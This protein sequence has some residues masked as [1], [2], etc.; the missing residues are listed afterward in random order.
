MTFWALLFSLFFSQNLVLSGYLGFSGLSRV[1]GSSFSKL[2]LSS[3]VITIFLVVYSLLSFLLSLV[4]AFFS[5]G[6]LHFFLLIS[7]GFGLA[8]LSSAFSRFSWAQGLFPHTQEF[9]FN[10]VLL[11]GVLFFT[12]YNTDIFSVLAVALGGGLGYSFVRIIFW[13]LGMRWTREVIPVHLKG[14]P[15]TLVA[16]GTLGL[17]FSCFNGFFTWGRGL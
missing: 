10:S 15:L 2:I 3:L 14:W 6:G 8:K 5:L 9:L 7:L 1:S 4:L 12:S 16:L 17:V 13:G 11:G